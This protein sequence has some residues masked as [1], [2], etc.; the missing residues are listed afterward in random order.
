MGADV[1][2]AWDDRL[3]VRVNDSIIDEL[4]QRGV[5]VVLVHEN[6]YAAIRKRP[7]AAKARDPDDFTDYHDLDAAVA[8]ME[9]LAAEH[10][11]MATLEVIGE[12]V[13]GRAIYALR[14][15]AGI[16]AVDSDRPSL[17]VL[18][19]H[20]AR[21]WI[22]VEVPLYYAKYLVDQYLL[23]GDVTR[24]VNYTETWIVPVL[25]PDGYAFSWDEDRLWRKN[26]RDNGDGTMGV[27]LNRNYT[28]GFGDDDFSS[29]DPTSQTYRG[30]Y[31]FSEPE[32]QAVSDLMAGVF[33]PTFEAAITYHSFAQL[34]LYPYGHTT[35]PVADE[36]MYM[37]LAEA[38][39][40]RINAAH[41]DPVNDY[42]WGQS[43]H[44]LYA[45]AGTFIDWAHDEQNATA[46]LTELR[47][48]G[49]PR[50]ELPPEEILP[51]CEENLPALMHLAEQQ[52][53]PTLRL[54][55]SDGD[56][57]VD[58]D[59]DC[60]ESPESASVDDGGCAEGERDLDGDGVDNTADACPDT[61]EGQAVGP[62]G[63]ALDDPSVNAQWPRLCGAIGLLTL[64][65][66][67]AGIVSL[68][69]TRRE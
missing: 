2:G 35:D 33:G 19:C 37:E 49:E 24:L 61:P 69:L 41:T 11:D 29:G 6:V 45:A 20:H 18:G 13:E 10:P 48:A 39:T 51:T 68:R 9:N 36:A 12:S 58:D 5:D 15:T 28:V 47:P 7:T 8:L 30:P 43:S 55:D 56:G 21:E 66:L 59:D 40:E 44:T 4:A 3:Y 64:F 31:A 32:T 57:F 53:I 23:D 34:V 60:P 17:L 54:L 50:F 16:D 42:E 1:F 38:M 25:N 22:S 26:R 65:G 27:D 67:G 46:I 62:D 63:C 52:L 14:I